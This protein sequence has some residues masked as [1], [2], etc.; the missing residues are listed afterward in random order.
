MSMLLVCWFAYMLYDYTRFLSSQ[1]SF[2]KQRQSLL[3]GA[4]NQGSVN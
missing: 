3:R 4:V 2:C 1:V